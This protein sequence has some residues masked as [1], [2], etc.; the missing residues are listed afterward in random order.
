MTGIGLALAMLT[1]LAQP[2]RADEDADTS[3]RSTDQ[4]PTIGQRVASAAANTAPTPTTLGPS[5]TAEETNA[6]A[7]LNS[8]RARAGLPAVSLVGVPGAVVNHAKYLDMNLW[9]TGLDFWSED[10]SLPGYTAAG[11]AVANQTWP[12][13]SSMGTLSQLIDWWLADPEGQYYSLLDPS[14]STVAFTRQGDIVLIWAPRGVDNATYPVNFP[15]GQNFGL[16]TMPADPAAYYTQGCE[17]SAWGFPITFQFDPRLYGEMWVNQVDVRID[18]SRIAVCPVN[19]VMDVSTTGLVT[20]VPAVV[21]PR[22]AHVTASVTA[23]A[24]HRD[25][26]GSSVVTS[27]TEFS[28]QAQATSTPGDQ[29]GDNTADVLAVTTSGELML[30][31]GRRPG[32][33]GYGFQVG[34]GW[35]EFTW[36]S[37][38]PD[39]NG[40]GREDLVGRRGDG[41]LYLYLGQGMGSYTAGRRVGQNWNGLRNL[42][43]VGDMNG[44]GTPEVIGIGPEGN[45]YRYT[46]TTNGFINASLIGKNWNGIALTTSVGSFNT[47]DKFA[48]LIAVGT[49]GNLYA[50]YSG[51]G[52]T[53]IQAAQIGRG[54]TGF[55]ALFSSGDLN[56]DARPDLVGR[57]TAGVLYSYQNNL[58]SWGPARQAGTGWNGIRLFG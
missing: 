7:R 44:D 26:S 15:A 56:G 4:R 23:T 11:D 21:L 10:P 40:D 42:T 53:I 12:G 28:V 38:T 14:I 30:Y 54:W 45:L 31:K 18:G 48:D 16:T 33:I 58:G 39:V 9:V 2:A 41:H 50:Y 34:R 19:N 52:G 29:T 55:T 6:V 36:F 47:G 51:P 3:A 35:N 13:P 43:V 22:G 46:L 25:G 8:Y 1:T 37:H 24:F 27:S 17:G 57:N 49:N 20:L 5:A 32:T